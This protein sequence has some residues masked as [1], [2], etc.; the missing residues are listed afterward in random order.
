[1]L[2]TLT[3]AVAL[4]AMTALYAGGAS[5]LPA[6]PATTQAATQAAQND[7]TLVRD[8][9]G[10]G[11]RFSN[12]RNRCVERDD[13]RGFRGRDRDFRRDRDGCRRGWRFSNRRNRCVRD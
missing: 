13:D 2:K 5:A 7:V 12:R 3:L 4:S 8:G 9:C 11:Q 10:R 1:M 6:A